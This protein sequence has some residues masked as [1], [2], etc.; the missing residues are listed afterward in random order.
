MCSADA[1]FRGLEKDS[2]G[3][4]KGPRVASEKVTSVDSVFSG[5]TPVV[6]KICRVASIQKVTSV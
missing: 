4:R 3:F 2:S 6:T 1:L 5:K